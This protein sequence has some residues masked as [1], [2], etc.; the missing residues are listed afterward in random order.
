MSSSKRSSSIPS[1]C[2]YQ[3]STRMKAVHCI[4]RSDSSI[5]LLL[6]DRFRIRSFQFTSFFSS[7][8][9][10]PQVQQNPGKFNEFSSMETVDMKHSDRSRL[11]KTQVHP[12]VHKSSKEPPNDSAVHLFQ[13]H[14]R[15]LSKRS[16]SLAEGLSQKG[17]T[18]P[19]SLLEKT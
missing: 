2:K 10:E 19:I 14:G 15:I 13:A 6:V 11:R 16:A 1:S 7:H 8:R 9:D 3:C 12:H 5:S 4:W 18:L 17:F